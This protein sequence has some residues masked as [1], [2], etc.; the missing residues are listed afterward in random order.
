M[1]KG[2]KFHGDVGS[3]E[4]TIISGLQPLLEQKQ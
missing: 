1:S 4:G 2:A 3:E